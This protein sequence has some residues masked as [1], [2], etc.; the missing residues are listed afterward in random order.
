[1]R[2]QFAGE[3]RGGGPKLKN[4][5]EDRSGKAEKEK[6]IQNS[7]NLKKKKRGPPF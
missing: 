6:K 7:V 5:R 4:R 2:L 1:L 3:K